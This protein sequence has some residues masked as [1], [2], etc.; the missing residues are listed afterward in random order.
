MNFHATVLIQQSENWFVAKCLDNSV[1]SQGK[2][3]DEAVENLK[4]ALEVY[5]EGNEE[6]PESGKFYV[7]S[8]D[9]VI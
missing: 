3:I 6:R 5:Y 8:L 2:T 4:E 9:M 7:T 1:A